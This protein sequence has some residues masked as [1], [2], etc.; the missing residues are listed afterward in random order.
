MAHDYTAAQ[1]AEL[2]LQ[3]KQAREL[4]CPQ[5]GCAVE[6]TD[7]P[8]RSDVSYVRRRVWILCSQCDRTVILDQR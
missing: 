5:C 8:P 7:V 1:R 2:A 4:Q 6:R 3:L